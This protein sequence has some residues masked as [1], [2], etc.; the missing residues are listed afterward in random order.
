MIQIF[1]VLEH[2]D[3]TWT[4]GN[5][6]DFDANTIMTDNINRYAKE[7]KLRVVKVELS[8]E[9]EDIDHG[10]RGIHVEKRRWLF[11]TVHFNK[12]KFLFF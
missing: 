1:Q 6:E 5:K 11:A 12:K 3:T 7:N 2:I 10:N 9:N 4:G 8:I